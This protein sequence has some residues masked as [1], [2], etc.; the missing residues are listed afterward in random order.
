M[1]AGIGKGRNGCPLQG[2][3]QTLGEIQG[4][5]PIIHSTAGC[6]IQSYVANQAG[7]ADDGFISGFDVPDTNVQ[8]RH[9]IFGG[10]S[11]LREQIKN[12]VKVLKGELYVVL[13]SCESAMVGDDI[14]A[15][16]KEAREQGLPV[17]DSILA[18]FHGD[19][20]TGYENVMADLFRKIPTVRY[21]PAEKNGK[22]INIL[23]VLPQLNPFFKGDLKEIRTILAAA[24]YEALTFFEGGDGVAELAAAQGA[25]LTISFSEWGN[26]AAE[27]LQEQY[28]IPILKQRSLPVGVKGVRSFLEELSEF[29]PVD[30]DRSEAMLSKAAAESAGYFARAEQRL[31]HEKTGRR[32]AVVADRAVAIQ[33]AGFLKDTFAAEICSVIVTDFSVTKER[34]AEEEAK[35]FSRITA[36]VAFTQ[37]EREIRKLLRRSGA[38]LILGSSFEEAAADSLGAVLLPVS[39][40]IY[41]AVFF[42][43]TYALLRGAN[44]LAEEYIRAVAAR[45][46][47]EEEAFYTLVSEERRAG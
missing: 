40:P 7:G 19:A 20:H 33:I 5:V 38:E 34:P 26:A 35:A 12:T 36:E 14:E 30:L 29:V 11:R 27:V 28:G 3:V 42:D 17:I 18:G 41:D 47:R 37:D 24:G 21:E 31:Y 32:I 44:T 1:S 2:A 9:V 22:R 6:G 23:G 39:Y 8:E 13:N 43:R 4:I 25:A 16:T 46:R 10:A 45:R 15:M